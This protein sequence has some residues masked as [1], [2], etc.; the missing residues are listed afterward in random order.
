[1]ELYIKN[2]H[3]D[4]VTLYKSKLIDIYTFNLEEFIFENLE[5][6]NNSTRDA[7]FFE[8]QP[9]KQLKNLKFIDIKIFN[10]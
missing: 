5:I 9:F 4:N 6:T 10:S 2:T 7:N 3:I 8:I 1:M